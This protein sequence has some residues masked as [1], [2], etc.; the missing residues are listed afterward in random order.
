VKGPQETFVLQQG[1][2]PNMVGRQGFAPKKSSRRLEKRVSINLLLV[3]YCCQCHRR[4]RYHNRNESEMRVAACSVEKNS[5]EILQVGPLCPSHAC[6]WFVENGHHN[7]LLAP[8]CIGW[9]LALLAETSH[10][11]CCLLL[12][13]T[14][15]RT[16]TALAW[17][18]ALDTWKAERERTTVRL[19]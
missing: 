4:N 11:T 10:K 13:S 7:S 9:Q 5:P 15:R 2:V 18:S 17:N 6:Y 14:V 19:R 1:L 16:T 12:S 3:V 8:S